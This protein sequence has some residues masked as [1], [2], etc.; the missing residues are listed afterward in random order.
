MSLTPNQHL[1]TEPVLINR[2]IHNTHDALAYCSTFRSWLCLKSVRSA[3]ANRT[4]NHSEATSMKSFSSSIRRS[5]RIILALFTSSAVFTA[6]CANMA[7]TAGGSNFTGDAATIGGTIHGGNQPVSA[8]TV[9]LWFAGQ[10]SGSAATVVAQTTSSSTGSFSFVMGSP[11]GPNAGPGGNTWSCPASPG[12]P[13]VYVV[14]TG[15]NTQGSGSSTNAAAA[16]V[17]PYGLCNTISSSSFVNLTEVTTVATMAVW[18]Q[19]YNPSVPASSATIPIAG[20]FDSDG[21]GLALQSMTNSYTL[22]ANLVNVATGTAYATKTIPANTGAGTFGVTGTSTVATPETAKINTIANILASCINSPTATTGTACSTLFGNAVAPD[23][24]TTSSPTATFATA[25]DTLHAAYYMLTNPTNTPVG[26]T[27]S[28]LSALFGLSPATGAPFQPSLAAAPTDWTIGI[29]YASTSTCGTNIKNLINSA[30]DLAVDNFGGVWLANNQAGGN[31]ALLSTT[32][33]PEVCIAMG[34]GLNTG[35]TLDSANPGGLQNIWLADSGAS[36]VYKYVPGASTFLAYPTAAAPVSITADGSGNIYYTSNSNLYAL[37]AAATT[38]PVTPVSI[39][40]AIGTGSRVLVDS[41]PAIWA[42]SGT[43]KIDRTSCTTPITTANCTSSATTTVSPTYGIGVSPIVSVG[44][45]VHLQNS[46]YF[47]AGTGSNSVSLFQGTPG[48]A[49]TSVTGWPITSGLNNPA[50]LAVDGAQNVWAVNNFAGANSVVEIG[51]AKQLLSSTTGF[52]K[53][54]SYLG[55]GRS[56]VI[57]SS[58]NVWIGRDGSNS[59]TEIVGAAVPVSQPYA[60]A[61]HNG[62]FQKIP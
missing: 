7:S 14:A 57:D 44:T 59:I 23:P 53:D 48:S 22:L 32:G 33:A 61:L 18:Q 8:A 54:V 62:T 6:G 21:T 3:R 4:V 27:S 10:G 28:N 51:A 19:Y 40:T 11:G 50:G 35:I 29:S 42:T 36:N 46:I 37:P 49:Y 15:G 60:L 16:F 39:A 30:Q 43:T 41:S 1:A 12:N 34:T 47:D 26:S 5:Q 20:S 17:A 56:L 38:S 24:T 52:V 31:V 9:Q 2:R 13:L 45:P 25:T 55:S 58:G